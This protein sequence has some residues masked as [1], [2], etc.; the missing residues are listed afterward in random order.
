MTARGA[1]EN[2]Q[3]VLYAKVREWIK[4]NWPFANV[5]FPGLDLSVSAWNALP[6]S[7]R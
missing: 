5:A 1:K 4:T 3:P 6:D 2:L 7:G